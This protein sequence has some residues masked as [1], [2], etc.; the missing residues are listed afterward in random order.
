MSFPS[1]RLIDPLAAMVVPPPLPRASLSLSE[2]RVGVDV[3]PPLAV[4]A[5][6]RRFR[7][8]TAETVEAILTLPA[9]VG[10]VTFGVKV[11]IDGV[12]Y[13]ATA[14][15]AGDVA[16]AYERALQDGRI[17]ISLERISDCLQ[18]VAI[19]PLGPGTEVQVTVESSCLLTDLDSDLPTLEIDLTVDPERVARHLSDAEKPLATDQEHPARLSIAFQSVRVRRG[20][21]GAWLESGQDIDIPCNQPVRLQVEAGAAH[22]SGARFG[23]GY[24]TREGGTIMVG[25]FPAEPATT[26]FIG[27]DGLMLEDAWSEHIRVSGGR[28]Y[29]EVQ[30]GAPGP[31]EVADVADRGFAAWVAAFMAERMPSSYATTLRLAHGIAHGDI[32]LAFVGP[33][34][35]LPLPRL[36]RVAIPRRPGS[37]DHI[38]QPR[39]VA[40][41]HEPPTADGGAA[42]S[43]GAAAGA[44][45][46]ARRR[47]LWERLLDSLR[48]AWR[49]L[50]FG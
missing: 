22:V 30:D 42:S 47:R 3:R 15:A 11:E 36:Q 40:A 1:D 20:P 37:S 27:A 44:S 28:I 38:Q 23:T 29:V 6:T 10:E 43:S 46:V 21:F 7:N 41:S 19:S 48:W 50:G 39:D 49:W 33:D 18:L 4:V 17:A 31:L 24:V 12:A 2:T 35:G 34:L 25:Y 9:P 16:Q 26:A 14:M 32:A 8:T 45:P 5:V 13:H